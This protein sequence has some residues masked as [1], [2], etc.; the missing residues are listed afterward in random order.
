MRPGRVR[1]LARMPGRG[2]NSGM[3]HTDQRIL[4]LCALA[5]SALL[6]AGCGNGGTTTTEETS[7]PAETTATVEATATEETSPS[8]TADESPTASG[9]ASPTGSASASGSASPSGSAGTG[10]AG[11]AAAVTGAIA[12]ATEAVPGGQVFE[13]DRKD[14]A[15]GWEVKLAVDDREQEVDVSEDG[16]EV[17]PQET[18]DELDQEDRERLAQVQVPLEEAIPTAL[19]EVDGELDGAQLDSEDGITVWEI[20]VDQP[21]GTSVDV[22]VNVDNGSVVKVDR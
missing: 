15:E 2:N 22:Y 13:I 4:P 14:G 19:D 18:D 6:V 7:A 11:E 21:D 16:S 3:K 8:A 5:L 1:T 17:T 12:A 10:S 20:D 9:S